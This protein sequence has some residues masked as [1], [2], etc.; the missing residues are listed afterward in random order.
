M[1]RLLRS[2]SLDRIPSPTTN[3]KKKPAMSSDAS[4]L[5][6]WWELPPRPF[7]SPS[8]FVW[9]LDLREDN[10]QDATQVGLPLRTRNKKPK[11]EKQMEDP[12]P[13]KDLKDLKKFYKIDT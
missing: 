6:N 9:E 7:P 2:G 10:T 3:T 12:S 5:R 4:K 8:R 13:I 1:K 11:I